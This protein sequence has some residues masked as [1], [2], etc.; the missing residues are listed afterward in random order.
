MWVLISRSGLAGWM[1][2]NIWQYFTA[3]P[4]PSSP[5]PSFLSELQF[6]C[7]GGRTRGST[8]N[9]TNT[10]PSCEFDSIMPTKMM[11]FV[12][13]CN[14][15]IVSKQNEFLLVLITWSFSRF[16]SFVN[17][18][19]FEVLCTGSFCNP[20]ALLLGK[21]YLNSQGFRVAM[22]RVIQY[23]KV[24]MSS[25]FCLFFFFSLISGN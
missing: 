25:F 15:Q 17:Q 11:L 10:F 20:S 7:C 22:K 9:D 4:S 6:L 5:P 1:E 14:L 16:R 21:F 18:P 24:S 8:S 3:V 12:H 2:S 13:L 19:L 23:R